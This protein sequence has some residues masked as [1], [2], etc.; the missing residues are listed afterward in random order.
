MTW[1]VKVELLGAN[2]VR[3]LLT[4]WKPSTQ[5]RMIRPAVTKGARIISRATKREA[6]KESGLLKKS[7]GTK[8]KTYKSGVVVG[9]IGPRKGFRRPVIVSRATKKGER[10]GTA[11]VRVVYRDPAKYAHLVHGGTQAHGLG[12]GSQ[13]RRKTREFARSGKYVRTAA[14]DA[15]GRQFG[16]R[17]P[18]ARANPFIQRAFDSTI[19]AVQ[20]TMLREIRFQV[21]KEIRKKAAKGLRRFAA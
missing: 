9:I 7:I 4:G 15:L 5:R 3:S 10:K 12:A 19:S 17:H 21:A 11:G 16:H 13:V 1:G 14:Y 18:G 20:A 2:Q 8:V 6:P